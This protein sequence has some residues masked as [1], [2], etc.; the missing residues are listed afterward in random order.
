M[1]RT[2]YASITNLSYMALPN[3]ISLNRHT[4]LWYKNVCLNYNN[5]EELD[6]KIE[7]EKGSVEKLVEN[8]YRKEDTYGNIRDIKEKTSGKHNEIRKNDS[9]KEETSSISNNF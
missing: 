2:A 9:Y 1:L 3:S 8:S 7:T 4:K 5:A 6:G